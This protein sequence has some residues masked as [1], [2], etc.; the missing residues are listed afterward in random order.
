MSP[1][2]AMNEIERLQFAVRVGL[3]NSFRVFLRNISSDTTV[4]ELL[5]AAKSRDIASQILQRVFS[6]SRLRVDFRYL[7]RFDIAL[8]TYLWVLSRTFPELAAAGAEAAVSLPRTWWSE[9]VSRY[10]LQ[11]L[12][13]ASNT[14][15][16]VHKVPVPNLQNVSVSNVAASGT[17]ILPE[18]LFGLVPAKEALQVTSGST[19]TSVLRQSGGIQGEVASVNTAQSTLAEPVETQ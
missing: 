16:D 11:G 5:A 8:A 3:A 4:K 17:Q 15:T 18:A 7:H 10:V 12:S 13:G 14:P 6:L 1:V 2:E 19:E 9:Q